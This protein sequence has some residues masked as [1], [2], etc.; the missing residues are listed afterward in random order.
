MAL[1][2]AADAAAGSRLGELAPQDIVLLACKA[3]RMGLRPHSPSLSMDQQQ[4][5]HDSSQGSPTVQNS[6]ELASS[7]SGVLAA[8]AALVTRQPWWLANCLDGRGVRQLA[9]AFATAELW[10]P[11]LSAALQQGLLLD[12]TLARCSGRDL[13]LLVW[14]L[15]RLAPVLQPACAEALLAGLTA[16]APAMDLV[17]IC[18]VFILLSCIAMASVGRN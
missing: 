6:T 1:A 11:R 14:S 7:P 3:A 15:A 2:A 8:A 4:D 18:Q 10:D 13:A 5:T 12:G 16:A 17:H 9:W